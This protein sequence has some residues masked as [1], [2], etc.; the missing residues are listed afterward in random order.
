[1]RVTG[2]LTLTFDGPPRLSLYG[3][4]AYGGF[5]AID[6][7]E[8]RHG[9]PNLAELTLFVPPDCEARARRAVEAFNAAMA[10][11]GGLA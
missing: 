9:E 2:P 5:L 10:D 1:M 8:I 3:S 11:E 7:R 6:I 4:R